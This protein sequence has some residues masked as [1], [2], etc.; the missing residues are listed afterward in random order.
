MELGDPI[1]CISD[2]A[3]GFPISLNRLITFLQDEV[4]ELASY[5]P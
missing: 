4:M 5:F 1:K 3:S 2:E